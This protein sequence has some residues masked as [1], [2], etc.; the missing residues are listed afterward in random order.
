MV[1]Y[2][3]ANLQLGPVIANAKLHTKTIETLL[4]FHFAFYILHFSLFILHFS[5]FI[6]HFSKIFEKAI[7]GF[8]KIFEKCK[9]KM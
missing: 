8:S 9:I 5:L 3:L 6:L 1:D 4:N 7:V 2:E